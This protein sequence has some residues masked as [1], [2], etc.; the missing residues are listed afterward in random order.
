MS[1]VNYAIE[2]GVNPV[3]VLAFAL[4]EASGKEQAFRRWFGS[5]GY[6]AFQDVAVVLTI[7]G[8]YPKPDGA[9]LGITNVKPQT[10]LEVSAA[11][12]EQF[13]GVGWPQLAKSVDLDMKTTA[14]YAKYLQQTYVADAPRAVRKNYTK[15]QVIEGIYNLG[16]PEYAAH[17]APTGRF[18]NKTAGYLGTMSGYMAQANTL[19]CA[20]GI[21]TCS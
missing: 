21:Y 5:A 9:S 11:F 4:Q 6:E 8:L 1:A 18:D 14:Y 16:E 7:Q 19:V 3:L 15:N 12:P 10:F 17:V 20:S 2:A 13:K